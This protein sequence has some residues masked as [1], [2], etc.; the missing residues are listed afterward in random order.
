MIRWIITGFI[1]LRLTGLAFADEIR[2]G[3]L[4]LK[5]ERQNS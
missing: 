4:E 3:Y 1:I 2:P 5:E